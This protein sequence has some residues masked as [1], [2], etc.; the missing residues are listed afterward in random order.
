[1]PPKSKARPSPSEVRV[2]YERAF[3]GAARD[4]IQSS[5]GRRLG[6]EEE[7]EVEVEVEV[8]VDDDVVLEAWC[9]LINL[10]VHDLIFR[11][12]MSPSQLL[13]AMP[14]NT[15]MSSLIKVAA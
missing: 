9:V 2:E 1:M 8:Q 11:A 7:E 14:P 6:E 15:T 3:G 13:L 4:V 10:H 5:I 12:C